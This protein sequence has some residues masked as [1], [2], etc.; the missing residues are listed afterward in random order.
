[1]KKEWDATELKDLDSIAKELLEFI[2][3]HRVLCFYGE[4]GAG[5]TTF[6]K[7]ICRQL[8][9]NDAVQSPTF[10]IVNEYKASGGEPIYHFDFYRLKTE[11]EAYDLGY[12]QYLFSNYFC[13]IEWPEKVEDLLNLK[14]VDLYLSFAD[15]KRQI[16]CEYD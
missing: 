14:K 11:E 10:S 15:A 1:M 8:G 5:K 7:A 3:D 16:K 6:I 12:E 13:F 9:V 4:L 2:G